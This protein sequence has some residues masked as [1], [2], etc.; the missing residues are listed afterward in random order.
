VVWSKFGIAEGTENTM[1]LRNKLGALLGAGLL[2]FAVAG[3]A[4]ANDLA[5]DHPNM[6]N[7]ALSSL[8]ADQGVVEDC[9]DFADLGIL[10]GAGEVGLH[11]ILTSPEASSGNISGSV[12]STAF[13]PIA[14]TVHGNGNGALQW[15]VVVDGDA[16]S[17]IDSATTDVNGGVLTL[18]HICFGAAAPTETPAAP[19]PTPNGGGGGDTLSPTQPPTDTLG[20]NSTGPSDGAWLLVV[21]LGV[22]L[23]SVVVL[24]P[25]RAKSRR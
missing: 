1:K 3:V 18:S 5:T 25:A 15:Y 14:N 13:G 6:I 7:T 24:T 8:I 12:D 10:P 2:T 21:A 11:F 16:N 19:T 20:S 23:A 17:V 4:F 22:L 9:T